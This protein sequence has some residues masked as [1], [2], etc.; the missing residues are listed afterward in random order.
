MKSARGM[1]AGGKMSPGPMALLAMAIAKL[2]GA[3]TQVLVIA[4][5]P[6]NPANSHLVTVGPA[7]GQPLNEMRVLAQARSMIEATR[8]TCPRCGRA[9]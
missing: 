1:D 4:T 7:A 3:Q 2:F 6:R 9:A 8:C 5:D